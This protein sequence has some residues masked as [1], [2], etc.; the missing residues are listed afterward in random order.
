M[1]SRPDELYRTDFYAWTKDQAAALRRLAELRPNAE[2]DFANLIEEVESLG[3]SDYRT[4]A[5]Q[6]RRLCAHALKLEFSPSADPRL[7]WLRT[8]D[9][10]REQIADTIS[11]AIRNDIE[12]E[13]PTLYARARKMAARELRRYGEPEAAAALPETCPYTLDQLLDEDW[14]PTNRHGLVDP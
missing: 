12:R 10:A 5:S 1:A 4:V 3:A 6:L 14:Y 13:W 11:A 7:G 8:I 2:I 9:D